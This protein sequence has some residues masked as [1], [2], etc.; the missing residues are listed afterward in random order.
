MHKKKNW[1]LLADGGHARIM[2]RTAPFGKLKEIHTL[3]HPHPSTH[4]QGADRPGRA[5]ESFSPTRHAYEPHTDPHERQKDEFARELAFLLQ[6]GYKTQQFEEL[7]IFS[8]PH[9]LGLLRRHLHQ[10]ALDANFVKDYAHI[11]TEH[12]KDIVSLPLKE[13]QDYIDHSEGT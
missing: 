7:H 13:V 8:A 2:E 1:V 12:A 5:F 6:E 11:V 4:E 3:N 9:M 10:G